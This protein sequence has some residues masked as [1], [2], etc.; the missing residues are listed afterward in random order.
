[1]K[2]TPR[3]EIEIEMINTILE[4]EKKIDRTKLTVEDGK[5]LVQKASRCLT[6]CEELRKSRDNW[7][8]RFEDK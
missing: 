8:N 5:L 2:K 3:S 4:M 6:K 1:M 7:R